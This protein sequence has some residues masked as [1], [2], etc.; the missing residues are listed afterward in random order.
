MGAKHFGRRDKKFVFNI[1]NIMIWDMLNIMKRENGNSESNVLMGSF[2]E[3]FESRGV[4]S[5]NHI[6]QHS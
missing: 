6:F 5:S 2:G 1:W 3:L 4:T